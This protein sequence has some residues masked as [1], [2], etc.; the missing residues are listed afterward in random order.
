MTALG[1]VSLCL[2]THAHTGHKYSFNNNNSNSLA[3][4][5]TGEDGPL[6]YMVQSSAGAPSICVR[7]AIG[8]FYKG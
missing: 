8:I 7:Q 1:L 2:Q 4:G 6:D 3:T 5:L